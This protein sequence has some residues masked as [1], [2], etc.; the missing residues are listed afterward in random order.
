[1]GLLLHQGFWTA[2]LAILHFPCIILKQVDETILYFTSFPTRSLK[3][4]PKSTFYTP[5]RKGLR[6]KLSFWECKI[7]FW[8]VLNITFQKALQYMMVSS[9]CVRYEKTAWKKFQ[10]SS[11]K[12]WWNMGIYQAR[13]RVR[14]T[15]L[16]KTDQSWTN[17]SWSTNPPEVP[18][19]PQSFLGLFKVVDQSLGG[20]R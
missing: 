16:G 14:K 3:L 11:P 5:K 4:T 7:A 10:K 12:W 19:L 6:C 1:M 20:V 8:E 2:G 17:H 9:T 13:I 15:S 18:P